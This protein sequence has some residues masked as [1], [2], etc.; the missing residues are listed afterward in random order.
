MEFA[1]GHYQSMVS[2]AVGTTHGFGHSHVLYVPL[3][4]DDI[5]DQVPMPGSWMHPRSRVGGGETEQCIGEDKVMGRKLEKQEAVA[6]ALTSVVPS[7][8]PFPG[9]VVCP[10]F[11]IEVP[12]DEKLVRLRDCCNEGVKFFIER[13]LLNLWVGHCWGICTDQRHVF[14]VPEWELE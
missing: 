6:V 4:G 11:S 3:P 9:L 1:L 8:D 5:F 2:P 7:N 14:L 13:S 12:E 10:C